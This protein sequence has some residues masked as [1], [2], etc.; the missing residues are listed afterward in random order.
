MAANEALSR[1]RVRLRVL[2]HVAAARREG[3]P[4][5]VSQ[6]KDPLSILRRKWSEVPGDVSTRVRSEDLLALSDDL[7]LA[8]WEDMV[9][10]DTE[11]SGFGVRGWYHVLYRDLLS[12]AKVLDIGCGLGISTVRFAELGAR[13]TFVDIV[14]SNIEV[15][16]RVCQLKGL[17]ADFCYMDSL[18]SLDRLPLD[19]DFVTALGSLIHAPLDLAR[20]EV[21]SIVRHLRNDGRWLHFAY[22]E[23]RWRR[24]G[25]PP[26][27]A[28]G[29]MTDGP[30]TPWAEWHDR[31][32][33]ISLFP[34]HDVNVLFDCE[35]HDG[36]FNWF[37]LKITRRS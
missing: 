9:E 2:K 27:Y 19:F 6:W 5:T 37:D 18:H 10:R 12:E 3:T 29:R 1:A 24:D 21:N 14:E 34:D 26:L 4:V 25:R 23:S 31:E 28:W 32:K 35:W 15:V 20:D 13:V 36:D 22:P 16:R 33:V 11:G 17:H 8:I 30:G 7:L